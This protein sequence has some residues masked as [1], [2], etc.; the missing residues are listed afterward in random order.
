MLADRF[1]QLADDK[2]SE[3]ARATQGL[4]GEE[5]IQAAHN[6]L[7]GKPLGYQPIFPYRNPLTGEFIELEFNPF[8]LRKRLEARGFRAEI[9]PP[10]AYK[11]R[12]TSAKKRVTNAL[13]GIISIAPPLSAFVMP[14]FRIRC[15]KE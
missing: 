10:A 7:Q 2:L 1:P 14:Y 5:V 11:Q 8:K 9:L 15:V 3:M 13:K 4:W 12:P 6:M